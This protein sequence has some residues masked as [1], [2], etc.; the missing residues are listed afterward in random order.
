[1]KK[2]VLLKII[3]II[4]VIPLMI[5]AKEC[6]KSDIKITSISLNNKTEKFKI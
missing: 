3:L 4:I 1:M 6:D 2:N 5:Y